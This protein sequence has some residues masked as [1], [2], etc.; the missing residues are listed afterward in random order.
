MG[1]YN[2]SPGSGWDDKVCAIFV[3]EGGIS[4]AHKKYFVTVMV[5]RILLDGQKQQRERIAS[6]FVC[7]ILKDSSCEKS[8]KKEMKDS[9]GDS[10]LCMEFLFCY[11]KY[12]IIHQASTLIF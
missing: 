10:N 9:A 12:T 11:N 5:H 4:D 6:T 8:E 3:A 2:I 1:G 7:A